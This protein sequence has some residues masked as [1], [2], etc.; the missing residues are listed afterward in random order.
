MES[1]APSEQHNI[2]VLSPIKWNINMKIV[3]FLLPSGKVVKITIKISLYAN[4]EILWLCGEVDY[5]KP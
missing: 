3:C 2:I 5:K 1:F 4:Y